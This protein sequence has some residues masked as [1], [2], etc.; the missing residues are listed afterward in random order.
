MTT[1]DQIWRI[2]RLKKIQVSKGHL[3][4]QLLSHPD[5]PSLM[6]ISDILDE[7][8]VPNAVVRIEKDKIREVPVPFMVH[9]AANGGQFLVVDNVDRLMARNP[10]FVNTWNGVVLAVENDG[11][12]ADDTARGRVEKKR[13]LLYLLAVVMLM[14]VLGF[15]FFNFSPANIVSSAC[16][17]LGGIVSVFIVRREFGYSD[18]MVEQLCEIG[19]STDCGS[20][21]KSKGTRL[22]SWLSISDLTIIYYSS[23]VVLLAL[24]SSDQLAVSSTISFLSAAAIPFTFFSIYYQ[25]KIAKK[26]C[27]LCLAIVATLWINFGVV[28]PR[29]AEADVFRLEPSVI[30]AVMLTFLCSAG[31]WL[32]AIRPAVIGYMETTNEY[33]RLVRFKR[34]PDVFRS[35]LEFRRKIDMAPLT[36]DLQLGTAAAPLK[37]LMVCN[38]LCIPCAAA[39]ELL[40]D[41]MARYEFS[42]TV[43]FAVNYSNKEDIRTRVVEHIFKAVAGNN[44]YSDPGYVSRLIHDWYE[45]MNYTEFV[46]QYPVENDMPVDTEIEEQRGWLARIPIK[47]TP[48]IFV[49]GYELPEQYSVAD[50]AMMVKRGLHLE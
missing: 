48:T 22:F 32:L 4:E 20:V 35:I 40:Y 37:V 12:V 15:I 49:C 23:M 47:A 9:T 43:R 17:I 18:M 28:V 29:F 42:L 41:L 3:K 6:S 2:L 45:Q 44:K 30:I 39:H 26:W 5:Y 33:F 24:L 14:T 16:V 34:N 19:K 10:N 11:T 21:L 27:V 1:P 46:R 38:P 31:I 50:L 36:H 7:M 13:Q 25:W 8:R